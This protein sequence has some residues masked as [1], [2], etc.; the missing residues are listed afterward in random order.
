LGIGDLLTNTLLTYN[1]LTMDF[2]RI[3]LKR[4][5]NCPICGRR[6]RITE[7]KDEE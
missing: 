2:R 3:G 5:L 1:A 7:L 4:N 6:P